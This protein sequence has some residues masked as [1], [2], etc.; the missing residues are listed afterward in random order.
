MAFNR[1]NRNDEAKWTRRVYIGLKKYLGEEKAKGILKCKN[2]QE[3]FDYLKK[4][5]E[6]TKPTDIIFSQKEEG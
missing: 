4:L 3:K 2:L 5:R 6:T 1:F